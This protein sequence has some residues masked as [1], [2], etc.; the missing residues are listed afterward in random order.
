MFA[1]GLVG[2]NLQ[3][4]VG[5]NPLVCRAGKYDDPSSPLNSRC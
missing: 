1:G 5:T 2:L 3:H 4:L